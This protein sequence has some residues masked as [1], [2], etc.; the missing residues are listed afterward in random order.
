MSSIAVVSAWPRCSDPVTFGG[1]ITITKRSLSASFSACSVSQLI[2]PFVSQNSDQPFSTAIGLYVEAHSPLKSFFNAT[3]GAALG[4]DIL[5]ELQRAR[6]H[7]GIAGDG[8]RGAGW[9]LRLRFSS[10]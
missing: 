5:Y 7:Q 1:G 8:A 6:R 9:A 4:V 2:S 3:L 10:R